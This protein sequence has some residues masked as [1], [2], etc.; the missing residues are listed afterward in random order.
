M[1]ELLRVEPGVLDELP[2]AFVGFV[3]SELAETVELLVAEAE[4]QEVHC[5]KRLVERWCRLAGAEHVDD[6]VHAVVERSPVLGAAAARGA[7]R[8]VVVRDDIHEVLITQLL[9]RRRVERPARTG[10][11]E[12]DADVEGLHARSR[13]R[14]LQHHD[15]A[16][17]QPC[18]SLGDAAQEG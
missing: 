9:E 13:L 4:G 16:G 8:H 1:E 14:Q 3:V 2:H 11:G 15:E 12:A 10:L 5:R 17:E 7:A 18:V 6:V